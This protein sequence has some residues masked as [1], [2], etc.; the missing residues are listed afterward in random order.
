MLG[1]A[2]HPGPVSLCIMGTWREKKCVYV[3]G[4]RLCTLYILSH[5]SE[6][7]SEA[8]ITIINFYREENGAQKV[9]NL[10]KVAQLVVKG[11]EI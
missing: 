7:L 6:P 8:G 3:E 11:A 9:S 1:K 5:L 4:T 2:L 10:P